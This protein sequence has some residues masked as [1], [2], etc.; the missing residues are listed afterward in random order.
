MQGGAAAPV[1][2]TV[3]F[4]LPERLTSPRI[5]AAVEAYPGRWTHHVMIGSAHE[6][7]DELLD[8]LRQAAAFSALKG[9]K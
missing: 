9:K 7:D 5:D 6:L 3:S 4:G 8:W 2:L 1:W